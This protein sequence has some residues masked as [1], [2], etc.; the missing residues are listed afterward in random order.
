MLRL[1]QKYFGTQG[2]WKT[3]SPT[4]CWVILQSKLPRKLKD[5][6]NFTIPYI[7]GNF[8]DEKALVDLRESINLIPCTI[9]KMLGLEEW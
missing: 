4:T 3:S 6:G 8:A 7:I 5:T 9:F 1:C 2:S